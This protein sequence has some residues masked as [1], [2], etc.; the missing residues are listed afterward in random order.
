MR[1]LRFGLRHICLWQTSYTSETLGTVLFVKRIEMMN[2]EIK[3][4]TEKDIPEIVDIWY[5]V[6]LQAHGLRRARK[7]ATTTV[8]MIGNIV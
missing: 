2:I 8:I 3:E 4:I 5:E 6:S 7:W 1:R